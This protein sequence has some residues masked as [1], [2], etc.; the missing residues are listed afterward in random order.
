MDPDD[1][2]FDG[3]DLCVTDGVGV[4][5]ELVSNSVSD[6][7]LDAGDVHNVVDDGDLKAGFGIA[8]SLDSADL[9][10]VDTELGD[11]VRYVLAAAGEDFGR[12]L[13]DAT[14]YIF[15]V[16]LAGEAFRVI[17]EVWLSL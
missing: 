12:T 7:V 17:S 10:M 14:E 15:S 11:D 3:V 13:E 16:D 6:L 8:R 4:L 5:C 9:V 1:G 2:V